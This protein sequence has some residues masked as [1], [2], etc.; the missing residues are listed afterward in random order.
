MADRYRTGIPGVF[1]NKDRSAFY[2]SRRDQDDRQSWQRC[3]TLTH[4]LAIRYQERKARAEITATPAPL[5]RAQTLARHL[6]PPV[7]KTFGR[8]APEWHEDTEAEPNEWW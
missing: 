1:S 7:D 4:A 3:T 8:Y 5:R 2:V 6:N